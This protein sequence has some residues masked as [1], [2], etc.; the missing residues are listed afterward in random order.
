[1]LINQLANSV[2]IFLGYVEHKSEPKIL[3]GLRAFRI[4]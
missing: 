4:C 2:I 1:M 3:A